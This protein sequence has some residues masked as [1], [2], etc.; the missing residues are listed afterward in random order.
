MN[1]IQRLAERRNTEKVLDAKLKSDMTVISRLNIE[2]MHFKSFSLKFETRNL[3][4]L[5]PDCD[6]LTKSL[7]LMIETQEEKSPILKLN[8]G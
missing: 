6:K 2:A 3:K 7:S 4:S 8:R 5:P 1:F